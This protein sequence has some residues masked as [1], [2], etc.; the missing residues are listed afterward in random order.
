MAKTELSTE[1]RVPWRAT[2]SLGEGVVAPSGELLGSAV[3][4]FQV[5][6]GDVRNE[7]SHFYRVETAVDVEHLL[8]SSFEGQF[9]T[10]SVSG[11]AGA[12]LERSLDVSER[13]LTIVCTATITWGEAM[14][15][16]MP[17]LTQE[18]VDTWH[19]DPLKFREAYGDYFIAGYTKR[20]A[21]SVFARLRAAD[22]ES[23]LKVA[24]EA[25]VKITS[26]AARGSAEVAAALK[27]YA[28]NNNCEINV[29]VY[30]DGV[31][32]PA[33]GDAVANQDF[34]LDLTAVPA[35]VEDFA[36]RAVGAKDEAI[37]I[38][39]HRLQPA[40]PT[41]I[42]LDPHVFLDAQR[43][44]ER[45]V[46][47]EVLAKGLPTNY[48]APMSDTLKTMRH[49]VQAQIPRD[50]SCDP[51]TVHLFA[52]QLDQWIFEATQI[53]D[54]RK[55]WR[56]MIHTGGG[57][58]TR[59]DGPAV[60]ESCVRSL[61]QPYRSPG[62]EQGGIAFD[63]LTGRRVCGFE[64]TAN[65]S[66][67]GSWRVSNGGLGKDSICFWFQSKYD[68]GFNWTVTVWT[69]PADKVRFEPADLEALS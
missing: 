58:V 10:A 53:E 17:A 29:D 46:Y 43:L 68:R 49:E 65:K 6:I 25:S 51:H 24:A 18:A 52:D 27:E 67:N 16:S 39:Y 4:P 20:A 26:L 64:V 50:L 14:P 7:E 69:A 5:T 57:G 8:A 3:E 35:H 48:R 40:I 15:A 1:A 47:A 32:A 33:P 38:H 30:K 11:T 2:A 37:L 56:A 62:W 12:R 59:W 19:Q 21:L 34:D 22:R 28:R 54:Y 41:T 44:H 63:D 13:S 66:D 60:I 42:D 61:R 55:L 31:R 9:D 36:R 23:L 45:F